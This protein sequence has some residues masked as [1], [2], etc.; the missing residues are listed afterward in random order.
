MNPRIVQVRLWGLHHVDS[1]DV[2]FN[3]RVVGVGLDGV[4]CR[5]RHLSAANV[6]VFATDIN[7]NNG[8]LGG[9]AVNRY[10]CVLRPCLLR[11]FFL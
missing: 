3:R 8:E 9:R 10:C 11:F 2:S 1:L 7:V 4:T 5:H 6:Y